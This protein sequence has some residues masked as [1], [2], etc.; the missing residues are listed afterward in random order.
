M[1]EDFKPV[2]ISDNIIDNKLALTGGSTVYVTGIKIGGKTLFF[3][4]FGAVSLVYCVEDK[5]WNEWISGTGTILWHRFT[6]SSASSPVAYSISRTSTSGKVYKLNPIAPV[7]SD[8]GNTYQMSIQTS[9][10]DLGTEN[11]KFLERLTIV[12]DSDNASHEI[13]VSWSDDDYTTYSTPRTLDLLNTRKYL[14]NCGS[15]RRRA[16]LITDS[17]TRPTRFEAIELNIKEG[18]H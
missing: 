17:T 6:A 10:I 15:F 2:R 11:R 8:D 18:M 5:T 16:F 1:L 7:Y 9:K 4:I 14:N 12:A 13:A 3:I